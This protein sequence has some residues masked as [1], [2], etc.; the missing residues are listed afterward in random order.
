MNTK[1]QA[2]WQALRKVWRFTYDPER[3]FL[4]E[5]VYR[6]ASKAW[7]CATLWHP[8]LDQVIAAAEK[9]DA[10]DDE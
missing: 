9:V 7:R 4:G 8:T 5:H 3:G 2:R 6:A 1:A 10:E